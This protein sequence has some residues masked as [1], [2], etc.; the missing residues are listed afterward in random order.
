M[1]AQAPGALDLYRSVRCQRTELTLSFRELTARF[2]H[3][4]SNVYIPWSGSG[5]GAGDSQA[6]EY[7]ALWQ[8]VKQQTGSAFEQ[9]VNLIKFV[10]G[11][12]RKST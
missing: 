9:W 3:M 1:D 2:R 11:V 5:F 4:R 10:V 7:D 8:Q 12:V 6:V